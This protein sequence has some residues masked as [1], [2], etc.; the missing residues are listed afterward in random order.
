MMFEHELYP[1]LAA[2]AGALVTLLIKNHPFQDGNKR[3]ASLALQEFLRRNG[4][5]LSAS[6]DELRAMHLALARGHHDR[7]DAS[8]WIATRLTSEG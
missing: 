4:H 5:M 2:K 6:D 7:P 3:I 1:S 8:S